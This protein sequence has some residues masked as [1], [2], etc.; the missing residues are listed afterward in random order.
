MNDDFEKIFDFIIKNEG[1]YINDLD[2]PGGETKYG[3][4]KRS[5]PDLIIS[6]LTI[7]DAKNIYFADYY[8]KCKCQFMS[9]PL[10]LCVCDTAVNMGVKKSVKILQKTL[11]KYYGLKLIRDG[12]IGNETMQAINLIT[13]RNVNEFCLRYLNN[14]IRCYLII[15]N[16]K[17]LKYLN[18]WINR[19][20]NLE[21]KF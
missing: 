5:Y 15:A 14:R 16:G 9:Y 3:I 7:E 20:C 11:N 6:K 4:S 8:M 17:M 19:V 21:K 10:A 1:G 13:P 2:D 12:I 18:G